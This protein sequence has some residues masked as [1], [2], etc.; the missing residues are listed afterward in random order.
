MSLRETQQLL[1][2]LIAAPQGVAAGLR[3]IDMTPAQ[4][5]AVLRGDERLTA[6]ERLDVYANMYFFRLLDI[7]RD[8]HAALLAC[9]GDEPFQRF[10]ADYLEAKP[11]QHPSVR[12]VGER[13]PDFLAE[14]ALGRERPWLA[15]L[16]RL[17]RTRLELFDAA[18]VETV[19]LDELR[20][21]A[22]E[23]FVALPLPLG[24]H[25]IL[26]LGW[27][28]DE[29]WGAVD[30]GLGAGE[31]PASPSPH[32]PPGALLVWRQDLAVYH[33][34]LEPLERAALARATAGAPFGAVCDLLAEALPLDQAGQAA[35]ELLARWVQDGLIARS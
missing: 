20:A 16:A 10:V 14:H 12:N 34:P 13:L 11:S 25:R 28:V 19:T 30:A 4:L 32:Q 7:L 8:E 21:L 18:D 23:A 22:P 27:A 31:T 24:P 3:Q 9:V 1:W 2:H 6:V 29:V 35:F 33:R 17:E 5:E 15:E 26:E